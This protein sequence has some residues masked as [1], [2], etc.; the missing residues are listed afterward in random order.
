MSEAVVIKSVGQGNPWNDLVF[1]DVVFDRNGA[2][3]AASWGKKGGGD[4][5]PGEQIE[6]EFY[7]KDGKWRFRKASKSPGNSSG[8]ST[9]SKRDWQPESQYDP[10]KTARITRS[11]AQEMALRYLALSGFNVDPQ[12]R[13]VAFH[14]AVL[15]VIDAFELDVEEAAAQKAAPGAGVASTGNGSKAPPPVDDPGP[16]QSSDDDI[17]F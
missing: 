4:P 13:M 1:Y 3:F 6:G 17:P 12:N 16:A 7:Q 11:H 2:D 5:V 9:S 10:E 15:P 14:Q 8:G